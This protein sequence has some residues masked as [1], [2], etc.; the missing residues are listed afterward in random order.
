MFAWCIWNIA[1][2]NYKFHMHVNVV[3]DGT[4]KPLLNYTD[5]L[6]KTT[7][8][9]ISEMTST[10]SCQAKALF[11]IQKWS[12]S[13][14]TPIRVSSCDCWK[15]IIILFLQITGTALEQ[16]TQWTVS[17]LRVRA[18]ILSAFPSLCVKGG[19]V[20]QLSMQSW[21]QFSQVIYIHVILLGKEEESREQEESREPAIRLQTQT[22]ISRKYRI[23]SGIS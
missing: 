12:L 1:N 17:F 11:K 6:N 21:R 7:Q 3:N 5:H 13:G 16:S 23:W 8:N 9:C 14:R 10:L 4:P 18:Y 2:S 22:N 19:R 20:V 15:K